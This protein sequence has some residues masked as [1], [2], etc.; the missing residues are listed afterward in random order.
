MS[1]QFILLGTGGSLGIPVVGCYCDICSSQDPVNKRFRSSGLLQVSGRNILFDVS[2]DV[3][4]ACL[5]HKINSIDGVVLT[6]LH[7][8]H[9]GGLN[10]LRPFYFYRNQR[11]IPLILSQRTYEGIKKRF[12]YLMDQFEIH[13]LEDLTGVIQLC[14]IEL[15][16]FTYSQ[17]DVVVNGFRYRNFAY[18]TDIKEYCETI[19]SSLKDLETLVISAVHEKGSLMHF[20]LQDAIAFFRKVGAKKCL[21]THI[22]HQLDYRAIRDTLP[23][24]VVLACDGKVIDV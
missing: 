19:F 5:Q 1:D 4:L 11:P 16:Y 14:D 10:D 12:A 15:E 6:H 8:D 3:R 23:E 20:S 13:I 24:N 21:I 2:P 18:V 22:N 7:D 9:V 17:K